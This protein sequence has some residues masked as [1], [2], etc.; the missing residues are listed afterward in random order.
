MIKHLAASSPWKDPL[1]CAQVPVWRRMAGHIYPALR[2]TLLGLIKR[3]IR[4][5][6]AFFF[7]GAGGG[8][9]ECCCITL[10]VVPTILSETKKI[11]PLD[12]VQ[13]NEYIRLFGNACLKS[14]AEPEPDRKTSEPQPDP[15]CNTSID[16]N[17]NRVLEI[18][19]TPTP[20]QNTTSEIVTESNTNSGNPD[21]SK[22]I[23]RFRSQLRHR[24][25]RG[26]NPFYA[27]VLISVLMLKFTFVKI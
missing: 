6:R 3:T 21:C 18:P 15:D 2:K 25:C 13:D 4:L 19:P 7:R 24:S 5:N 8:S 11:K 12:G 22:R 23:D 27:A 26:E 14:A 9:G 16:T 10:E 20:T 17:P 1:T